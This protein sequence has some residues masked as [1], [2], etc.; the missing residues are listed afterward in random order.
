MEKTMSKKKSNQLNAEIQNMLVVYAEEANQW[1]QFSQRDTEINAATFVQTVVLGWLKK[2]DA[3]LNELAQAAGDLGLAVTGSAL[4]ERMGKEAVML[5][6]GVL[7]L[8]LEELRRP[9]PLPLAVLKRFSGVYIT[10]SSQI[11]L[12]EHMAGIFRGN[13]ANSMLKL[14]VTW[15]YLNGN[16]VALELEEGRNPDQKC[17]L[18]VSHAQ[19]GTLQ[20]F[21]LGYFKQEYLRDIDQQGAYFVS[22]Y[23]SQTALYHPETGNRLELV[24]WLKTVLGNEA[25]CRVLIG[26][27][28]QWP[29]RLLV[30]RLSQPAADARRRKAKQQ[31]REQGKTCSAAYL[32]LLGWDIL[33][34]NLAAED[35]SLA[36]IFDLYPIRF[37]I[38]WL[39]RVWKDQLGVDVLGTWRTERIL[40]QL[41]AHLLAAIL[42]HL[43]TAACRWGEFEHS[44]AKCVQVIQDAVKD[45]LRCFARDG[46][47]ITAWLK[48][49]EAHFRVFGCKTQRRKSPSTAQ[50]IYN[51]GLS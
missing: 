23:Q 8:T 46:W 5:L 32:F 10:D 44:F 1:A 19:A 34:T 31:A 13:Q 14:Q 50:I 21:D 38:E 40:C 7:K 29:V 3:S 6:A 39:F 2:K 36:Q 49:L 20:L 51:W 28:V 41:Y 30:R 33:V 24:S 43:L 47:G 12:P 35:W 11:A 15:D 9:C 18:H 26:G 37:Q 45:L 17:R 25:E 48:R 22:R 16:L 42:T 4:H 27:R